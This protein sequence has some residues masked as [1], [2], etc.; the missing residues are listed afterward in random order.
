VVQVHGLGD[1]VLGAELHG[2]HCGL[3]V[4]L[5]GEENDGA[6]LGPQPLEDV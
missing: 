3:D 2:A 5:A 4:T 1:E 6:S